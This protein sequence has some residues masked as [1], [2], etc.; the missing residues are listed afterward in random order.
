MGKV[1]SIKE[2]IFQYFKS[3]GLEDKFEQYYALAYW[4]KV[5]GKEIARHTEPFRVQDGVIF[6]HVDSDVWRTE[7]QYMK[8]EIIEKLNH[9]LKKTVIQDIKFY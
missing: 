3:A 9:E 1:K 6:V 8:P 4:Q 7:L 2:L 5:V